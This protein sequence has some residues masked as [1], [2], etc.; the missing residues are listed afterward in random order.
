VAASDVDEPLVTSST[1]V[2]SDAA[3]WRVDGVTC[4]APFALATDRRGEA[5]RAEHEFRLERK[6]RLEAERARVAAAARPAPKTSSSRRRSRLP[7]PVFKPPT[8]TEPFRLR[9]EALSAYEKQREEKARR[10]E[11]EEET[12]RR[13]FVAAPLPEST[14]R[15]SF[16]ARKSDVPLTTPAE[17]VLAAGARRA[18]ARAAFDAEMAARER[19]RMEEKEET[20][21]LEEKEE[22]KARAASRRSARFEAAPV[23]DYDALA[24]LGVAPVAE[25]ALTRPESPPLRTNRRASRWG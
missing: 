9:G 3:L 4:P 25:R 8:V 11:K 23:P 21:R 5:A 24:S 10:K 16:V 6:A 7:E 14:F 22:A 18:E 20:R 12:R 17:D 1:N 15:V 19:R 13:R 2:V